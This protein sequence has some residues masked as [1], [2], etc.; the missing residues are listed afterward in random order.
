MSY[1]PCTDPSIT[2]ASVNRKD[3]SKMNVLTSTVL[4][5]NCFI[6]VTCQSSTDNVYQIYLDP[7]GH[8]RFQWWVDYQRQDVHIKLTAMAVASSWFAVGFSDY[9]AVTSAD[10]VVFWT[11]ETG[12]HHFVDGHTDTGG[13]LF[14]DDHQDYNLTAVS[15]P[16]SHVVLQFHRAFDTCDVDD[17]VIDSGTTHVIFVES[18]TSS[19]PPFGTDI[20]QV[21]HGVQRTQILKPDLPRPTFPPDTWTFEVVAPQIEVP[22]EETTYWWQ[23]AML[24]DIA[25][26]HHIIQYEGIIAA[27]SEDLVHH[28]EVFHCEVDDVDNL[29]YYSG[30]GQSEGMPEGLGVCR[31]VIGAWAMGAKAMVY[32]DE[33]GVPIGGPSYSRA[34]LL[35]VHYNNPQRKPGRVDSSGIRFY[36]T[37]HIRKNDAAIM[38][39]GLE[40]TNK[41]AIPPGQS[42]FRLSGYC[43]QEC[44]RVGTYPT[45]F[46]VFASQL[47]THQTGKRVFTKHVRDGLELPELNRDNHYSPHFQEIRSLP[48]PVHVQPGDDLITTCEYDT[49]GRSKATVGGFSISD[50]MCVNYIH[51]YP[52][53]ELEVCKSSLQSHA[54][55]TFLYMLNRLEGADVSPAAGYRANYQNI[56]W[57]PANVNLLQ[58]LYVTSYLSMQCNKSDGSRFPG[59]WE[60]SRVPD[61]QEPFVIQNSSNLCSDPAS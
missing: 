27:G 56:D 52:K 10:L 2:P 46:H 38:E 13:F 24:P 35:E 6:T 29:P 54:L 4:L 37:S 45:G 58:M 50:E 39:L 28:M 12:S 47:H 31:K 1:Q 32:P 3:S 51:Y 8:F 55:D 33:A 15:S 57:S 48:R 61:I 44:T 60:H 21:L 43:V 11:D 40:Y 20:T 16:P 25:S 5:L 30:P 36:V 23:T 42:N 53:S 19:S 59:D 7:R 41:M 9:G 17:Y 22:A 26:P 18:Q 34:A 14:P 49:S